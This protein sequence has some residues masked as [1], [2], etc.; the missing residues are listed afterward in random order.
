MIFLLLCLM[1]SPRDSYPPFTNSRPHPINNLMSLQLTQV[2]ATAGVQFDI[3]FSSTF[4]LVI[5]RCRDP[6]S[7]PRPSPPFTT[8]SSPH[9]YDGVTP[10]TFSLYPQAAPPDA[11]LP[12]SSETLVG[13]CF[14]SVFLSAHLSHPPRCPCACL[15]P[16]QPRGSL[17]ADAL[18]AGD[19]LYLY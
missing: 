19:G 18:A 9:L 15:V 16:S 5:A 13:A 3:L 4:P 11:T 10:S 1:N 7:P 2:L 12:P 6:F 14:L 8:T 17:S